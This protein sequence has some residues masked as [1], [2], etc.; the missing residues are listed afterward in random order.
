MKFLTPG[1]SLAQIWLLCP[2]KKR[3]GG[4]KCSSSRSWK[5]SWPP[6]LFCRSFKQMHLQKN[7]KI[8]QINWEFWITSSTQVVHYMLSFLGK[9]TNRHLTSVLVIT[10]CLGWNPPIASDSGFLLTYLV[11]AHHS[12]WWHQ[13]SG[14][15]LMHLGGTKR[16]FCHPS[17]RPGWSLTVAAIQKVNQKMEVFHLSSVTLSNKYLF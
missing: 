4:Y 9:E 6:F 10:R 14:F 7:F 11:M 2:F 5:L 13:M 16:W 8:K 12:R 15:S 1:F 3:N 17:G